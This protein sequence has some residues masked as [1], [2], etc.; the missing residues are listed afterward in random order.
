MI[1]LRKRFKFDQNKNTDDKISPSQSQFST[2]TALGQTASEKLTQIDKNHICPDWSEEIFTFRSHDSF[3]YDKQICLKNTFK[4]LRDYDIFLLKI[5]ESPIIFSKL[6]LEYRNQIDE[7]YDDLVFWSGF[8]LYPGLLITIF[9]IIGF[10][11]WLIVFVIFE[12]Q[13]LRR[14]N[15]YRP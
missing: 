12:R 7:I 14:G 10:G 5:S 6:M 8:S 11:L 3:Y 9:S 2:P 15:P 1:E 13:C 4:I